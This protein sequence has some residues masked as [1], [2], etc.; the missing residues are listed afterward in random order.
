VTP[1]IKFE[2]T[3]EHQALR[4]R[5]REV[6]GT[7]TFLHSADVIGD[8]PELHDLVCEIR[9]GKSGTGISIARLSYGT[10]IQQITFAGFEAQRGERLTGTRPDLQQLH[11]G[12][13]KRK[14]TLM[15]RV[16]KTYS[17]SS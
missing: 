5:F 15:M 10:G 6:R 17:S 3:A 2:L 7:H 16:T 13:Q 11:T 9:D 4:Q 8:A 14:S 12:I 1:G